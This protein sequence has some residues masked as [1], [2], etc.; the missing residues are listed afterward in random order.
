MHKN[1]PKS[2]ICDGRGRHSAL[3]GTMAKY[4]QHSISI[5]NGAAQFK[6][7]TGALGKIS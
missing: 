2:A 1:L 7:L 5:L 4:N 6:R 3:F